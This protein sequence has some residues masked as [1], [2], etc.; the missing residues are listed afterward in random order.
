[1]KLLEALEVFDNCLN[2][3]PGVTKTDLGD[4]MRYFL[5]MF[6]DVRD[7]PKCWCA[8]C[9]EEDFDQYMLTDDLWYKITVGMGQANSKDTL[10][11]RCVEEILERKLVAEDFKKIPM[12]AS[13]IY[14]LERPDE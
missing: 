4:A 1:M 9:G 10:H 12:N 14:L 7:T 8:L 2:Q 3:K 13:I 5:R 11:L 6:R